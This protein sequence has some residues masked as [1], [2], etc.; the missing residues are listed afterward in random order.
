MKGPVTKGKKVRHV[1]KKRVG[2]SIFWFDGGALRTNDT[3]KHV[4]MLR[5][6]PSSPLRRYLNK[7]DKHNT[8]A[9]QV[10]DLFPPVASEPTHESLL[11][12]HEDFAPIWADIV[13]GVTDEE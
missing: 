2:M 13:L 3:T 10:S 4:K 7:A 12:C 5:S 8:S 1:G 6:T 9:V 11:F